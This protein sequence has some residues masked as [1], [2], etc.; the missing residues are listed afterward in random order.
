[1]ISNL[2]QL[3]AI[4]A[5]FYFMPP[6]KHIEKEFQRLLAWMKVE[7]FSRSAEE[8]VLFLA[9]AMKLLIY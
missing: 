7:N 4:E 8:F 3:Q 6:F 2:L 5:P 1:V 9:C